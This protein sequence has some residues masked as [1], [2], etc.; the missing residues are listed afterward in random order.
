MGEIY[1][2][3]SGNVPGGIG[4]YVFLVVVIFL[5]LFGISRR[6]ELFTPRRFRIWFLAVWVVL[7]MGYVTFWVKDP[8]ESALHRYSTH[9]YADHDADRWLAYFFRDEISKRLRPFQSSTNYFYW[10][11]W[12]Y[13]ADVDCA[14]AGNSDCLQLIRELPVDELIVGQIQRRGEQYIFRLTITKPHREKVLYEEEFPFS[15]AHPENRLPDILQ[16]IRRFFPLRKQ[17]LPVSLT[18]SLLVMA[19]DA[20]YRRDY[21][22]S[23]RLCKLAL[24]NNP[25]TEEPRQWYFYNQIRL[26]EI[27][28]GKE[29]QQKPERADKA[30]WQIMLEDARRFLIP[31]AQKQMENGMT[32]EFLTVMIAES[33]MLEG[34][35]EDAE[36]FLKIAYGENPFDIHVLNAISLLHPTRYRDLRFRDEEHLLSKILHICPIFEEVLQRYVEKLLISVP[37]NETARLQTHEALSRFLKLNPRSTRGWLLWGKYQNTVFHYPEAYQAFLQA[38]SLQPHSGLIQYN[39][40]V[41]AFQMKDYERAETHF[42]KAIEWEDHLDAHLYL[43]VIYKNRGEYE[44]ALAEFR[45]RVANKKSDDDYYAIQAMKGIRECLEALNIP[46]PQ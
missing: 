29:T 11:R 16:R 31:L 18:D 4:L 23:E 33:F 20:F 13:L 43:G 21:T 38:D 26:A 12:N 25:Q 7:T 17:S 36:Q 14:D 37:V 19:K 15:R 32:D 2:Y 24:Q 30:D 41:A 9:I 8:P 10:Q 46:I 44:K 42:R 3:L 40:G 1:R 22:T 45:Y 39:L 35:F 28:K 27:V 34:Y 5:A 6:N